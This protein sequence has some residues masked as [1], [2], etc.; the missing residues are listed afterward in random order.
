MQRFETLTTTRTVERILVVELDRPDALNAFDQ[1]MIDELADVFL[2]AADDV[3]VNVLVLTGAGRAFSAGADLQEMGEELPPARHGLVGLLDAIIDFPK[4]FVVAING[5]G[6]GIGATIAGLADLAWIADGARLR[7]PFTA[8]GVTAEV[9][10][11]VTFPALMGHQRASWF[12][13]SS[14]WFDADEVVAAGLALDVLPL[15]GFLA[16]VLDHAR[17]LATKPQIS[18]VTTK[19]LLQDPRRAELKAVARAE[20][21]A[22]DR[23]VGAP[24]NREAVAAFRERRDPD[25]SALH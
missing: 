10:S 4:P 14:E 22:L 5:V 25:F 6:A 8:L 19:G 20:A 21:A 12:L 11:T 1:A 9:A 23:L 13:L 2:A 7:C 18:L 17:V 3:A 15:D 16:A 24:V